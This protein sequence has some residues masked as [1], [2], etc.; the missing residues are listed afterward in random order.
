MIPLPILKY[1]SLV[2]RT[3]LYYACLQLVSKLRPPSAQQSSQQEDRY[4]K[5]EMNKAE[6]AHMLL[7]VV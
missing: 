6:K 4:K 5:S 1:N 2:L 7:L 3:T